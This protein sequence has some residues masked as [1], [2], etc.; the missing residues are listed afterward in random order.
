[1]HFDCQ[2][3]NTQITSTYQ[4]C[5]LL[6]PIITHSSTHSNKNAHT[7]SIKRHIHGK[8]TLDRVFFALYKPRNKAQHF[9]NFKEADSILATL[10]RN[11]V[12]L[13]GKKKLWRAGRY[14]FGIKGYS[15]MEYT[16]SRNSKSITPREEEYA[17]QKL[18]ERSGAK[19]GRDFDMVDDILDKIKFLKN[20]AVDGSS[21]TWR[22]KEPF[23]T[24]Y[25]YC[26]R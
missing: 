10:N 7:F 20:I 15:H 16:K 13:N 17:T 14:V 19:V 18:R 11:N 2:K 5:Q 4:A 8:L 23:K 21:C 3:A 6:L 26:R 24:E 22:V 9:I 12:Y 1:M 25:T